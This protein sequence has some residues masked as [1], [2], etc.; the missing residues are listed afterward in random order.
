MSGGLGTSDYVRKQISKG[1][2]GTAFRPQNAC[3][4]KL[5][6]ADEPSVAPSEPIKPTCTNGIQA[7]CCRAWPS[8][9]SD[10]SEQRRTGNLLAAVL[11]HQLWHSLSSAVRSADPSRRGSSQGSFLERPLGREPNYVDH[12]SGESQSSRAASSPEP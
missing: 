1:Y 6:L 7:T 8:T 9:R 4:M 11:S 3:N 2:D 5:L 12:S 10:P